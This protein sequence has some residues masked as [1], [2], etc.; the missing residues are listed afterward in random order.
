MNQPI[1]TLPRPRLLVVTSTYPRWAGDAEPGFVHELSRRLSARF[2]VVVLCPH[3]RGA[4]RQ[5]LLDG[6]QVR[7][8]AYA[9]ARWET[10]VNDGGILANL[11][12]HPWKWL[13]LPGFVLVQWA[14]L[15]K[16]RWTWRP[17]IIHAHWLLPQG[18][19]AAASG[20]QYMVVTSHGADLFA[21][22]TAVF[23]WL[24]ARVARRAAAVTV[25]SDAMRLRLHRECPQ[26][27]VQ[28]MPMG[29]DLDG[30][31]TAVG[32]EVRS[33]STILFVG[34]L[35]AKKGL[36][37]L[38][39]AMPTVLAVRP[40]VQLEI[41]GFGPELDR[42]QER[43][44][45]LGIGASV[46]FIGAVSQRDLP[47][48]Y[49]RAAV[50]VAPFIEA[51]SG[52]QEGLGLVV[53]EAIGCLCP[54]VVGDVPAVHDVLGDDTECLVPQG[55]SAAIA[56]AILRVL[57]NPAEARDRTLSLRKRVFEQFSWTSVADGYADLFEA[58]L[59]R[60]GRT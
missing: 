44:A 39:D 6:V 49:R 3:A 46:H 37:H 54:V 33:T 21:L 22:K 24:R 57:D 36:I 19:V 32:S 56:G 15:L 30:H 8:Y 55:D 7:R 9:P 40:D 4:K 18:I 59:Q 35:V 50:F 53:A 45:Q 13:L 51:T 16:L 17:D 20:A 5:E 2:D 58:L 60:R 41:V 26:A 52:D 43:V 25:V 28:T 29:V 14:Q 47:S 31:F 1:K 42:L 48:R 34:R 27:R 23:R 38:I 10:L 12:R 11:A